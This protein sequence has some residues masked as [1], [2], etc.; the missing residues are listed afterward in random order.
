[1][2]VW[3]P[4]QLDDS[5]SVYR[6]WLFR[7]TSI[8]KCLALGF[9]RKSWKKSLLEILTIDIDP[10]VSFLPSSDQWMIPTGHL[11]F[12]GEILGVFP[13]ST[14][15][16]MPNKKLWMMCLFKTTWSFQI[17]WEGKHSPEKKKAVKQKTI[18]NLWNHQPT[19]KFVCC[20]VFYLKIQSLWLEKKVP[21]Y[22]FRAAKTF[23]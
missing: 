5:K 23:I 3:N 1:M 12:P 9:S 4:F 21:W 8:Y 18:Q 2:V 20:F 10:G 14:L 7:Q 16:S 17:G 11:W 15:D 13:A 22:S 19:C 6:K